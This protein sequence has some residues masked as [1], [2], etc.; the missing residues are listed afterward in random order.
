MSMRRLLSA[1]AVLGCATTLV[2]T[3]AGVQSPVRVAAALLTLAVAPGAAVLAIAAPRSVALEPGLVVGLS[4]GVS[5][6]ATQLSLWLGVW[7]PERAVAGLAGVCL[8][9]LLWCLA[10]E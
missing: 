3:V 6:L 9:V 5:A 1:L 2:L 8:I 4:L 7:D 10:R